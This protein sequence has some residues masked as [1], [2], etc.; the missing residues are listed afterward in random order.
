MTKTKNI[1]LF[2][3]FSGARACLQGS[4]GQTFRDEFRTKGCRNRECAFGRRQRSTCRTGNLTKIYFWR[5]NNF[6]TTR[7]FSFMVLDLNPGGCEGLR[8]IWGGGKISVHNFY[9]R[10]LKMFKLLKKIKNY[11]FP[12]VCKEPFRNFLAF[13]TFKPHNP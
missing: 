4:P 2:I 11:F 7:N 3:L 8:K 12:Q 5:W 6:E 9:F 13:K 1:K 10:F